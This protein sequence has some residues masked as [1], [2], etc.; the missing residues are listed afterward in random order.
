MD[1]G[2]PGQAGQAAKLDKPLDTTMNERLNKVAD[3]LQF[4]CQ[5]IE[6]VLSRVNGTRLEPPAVTGSKL[7]DVAQIRPQH[8]MAQVIELI[9]AAQGRLADLATGVERIA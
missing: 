8:A 2:Y 6:D 5:R 1:M 4:Q 7:G 3:L 9:E